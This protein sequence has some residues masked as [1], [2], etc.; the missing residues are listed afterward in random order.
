V[1]TFTDI[2]T[3]LANFGNNYVGTGLGDAD[4]NAS[5]NFTDITTVLANFGNTCN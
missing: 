1:V 4:C 2:T 5:V 3:V